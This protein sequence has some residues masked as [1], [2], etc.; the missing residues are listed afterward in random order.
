MAGKLKTTLL[1]EKT[2]GFPSSIEHKNHQELKSEILL[3]RLQL[4]A[5]VGRN[6]LSEGS[7]FQTL[8]ASN[9]RYLHFW[10]SLKNEE[11]MYEIAIKP[12]HHEIDVVVSVQS[13]P[14]HLE[15][16]VNVVIAVPGEIVGRGLADE[17]GGGGSRYGGVFFSTERGQT[18]GN[19]FSVIDAIA[20]AVV[21]HSNDVL[22][23]AAVAAEEDNAEE[24]RMM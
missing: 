15:A 9:H 18:S 14:G 2:F 23:K 11:A 16:R 19:L 4:E 17:H 8:H 21:M 3:T 22:P 5:S 13:R 20:D 6:T 1:A 10:G 12:D 7:P 24:R